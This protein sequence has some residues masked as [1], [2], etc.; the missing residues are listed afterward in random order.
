MN[1][2]E[3]IEILTGTGAVQKGHFVLS[4]G[5]H[6]DTYYQCAKVFEHPGLTEKLGDEIAR[7]WEGRQ[8]DAV[9]SPAVGGLIL[10]FSVALAMGARFIFAERENE[11]MKLRR[12]FKIDQD[13]RILVVE[14]V[15][16]TGGSV[17]E[18]IEIIRENKGHVVGLSCLLNRGD[19]KE[20]AGVQVH[21]L[22]SASEKIYK[23]EECPLEKQGLPLVSPGSRRL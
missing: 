23:P 20:M 2:E 22:V 16:T 9:I 14:D 3:I 11:K 13:E 4:S 21:S 15:I 10:G 19:K 7:F 12:G 18:V 17:R 5:L 8:I 1:Q 6:S